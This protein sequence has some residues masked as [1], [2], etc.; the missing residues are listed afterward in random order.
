MAKAKKKR[1]KDAPMVGTGNGPRP[2][3]KEIKAKRSALT[4]RRRALIAKIVARTAAGR[5]E[6]SKLAAG[7]D[8]RDL[9][10]LPVITG[11]LPPKAKSKTRRSSAMAIDLEHAD[12]EF[13]GRMRGNP[14]SPELEERAVKVARGARPS[15]TRV[16]I[17]KPP[18]QAPS[19]RQDHRCSVCGRSGHNARN[20]IVCPGQDAGTAQVARAA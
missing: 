18:K 9:D 17:A 7:A 8:M 4:I 6:I 12:E 11:L 20:K 10:H 13:L 16:M 3:G 15:K 5:A 2:A 14:S 1:C 19:R